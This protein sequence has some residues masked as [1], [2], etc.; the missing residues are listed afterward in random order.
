MEE[1]LIRTE[2]IQLKDILDLFVETEDY[3]T[4]VNSLKGK[5]PC[6]L[7]GSRGVGKS[8][9]LKVTQAELKKEFD[10]KRILP[11]YVSFISSPLLQ[12]LED[13]HFNAWMLSKIFSALIRELNKF[14]ISSFPNLKLIGFTQ[15][16]CSPDDLY[17]Q[18]EELLEIAGVSMELTNS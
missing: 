18:L 12:G 4:I 14:G 3:R 9:L 10:I 11:V 16:K 17:A 13:K 7:V 2:D 8:F 5:M 6:I 15:S 1:I